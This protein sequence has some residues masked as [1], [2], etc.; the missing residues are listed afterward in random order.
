MNTKDIYYYTN[1]TS[2]IVSL[3]KSRDLRKFYQVSSCT[4]NEFT[5]IIVSHLS[6][7]GVHNGENIIPILKITE[8]RREVKYQLVPL[9]ASLY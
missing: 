1:T 5:F 8:L 6:L 2:V 9:V 4:Q 3:T 7:Y